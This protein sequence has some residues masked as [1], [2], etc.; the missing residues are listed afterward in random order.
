M[1]SILQTTAKQDQNEPTPLLVTR[2]GNNYGVHVM[3]D[4]RKLRP[5]PTARLADPLPPANLV[6][7]YVHVPVVGEAGQNHLFWVER[8]PARGFDEAGQA[9]F[10]WRDRTYNVARVL[11][12]HRARHRVVR[13]VNSCGL[14]QCVRP[15]HWTVEPSFLG[16]VATSAGHATVRIGDAWRLSVGGEVI[17]RDVVFIATV[18]AGSKARHVVRALHEDN[19]TV[20]LTACGQLADPALVVA[21][22]QDATCPG[23][24]S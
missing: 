17:A 10:R 2:G 3:S 9:V 7:R 4:L 1:F 23:C 16:A 22:P 6:A 18:Q 24:V 15:E 8:K 11:L 14:P 5:H 20:F 13:A 19:E 12:Q 21:S